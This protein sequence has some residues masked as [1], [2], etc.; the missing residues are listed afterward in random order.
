MWPVRWEELDDEQIDDID[1]DDNGM[2]PT[3][4]IKVT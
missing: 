2:R 3:P 4:T 1:D